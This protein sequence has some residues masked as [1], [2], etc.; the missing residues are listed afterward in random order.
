MPTY[1]IVL[2][3]LAAYLIG[4][5]C[6]AVIVSKLCHLPDPRTHGSNNP[7]A[8]N[9]LRLAGK[10]MALGVLLADALK[11]TLPVVIAKACHVDEVALGWIAL[12]AILG[13]IYPLFFAFQ[14]GKGVATALGALIGLHP[15]LAVLVI[16]TWVCVAAFTRYSSLASLIALGLMPLY[17]LYSLPPASE[18]PL[19]LIT[20]LIWYQH[21]ANW[22]RLR[23]G[24][25]SKINFSK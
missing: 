22:A 7:G 10:W 20:L 8:T 9:V 19:C 5:L 21:R 25:E 1:V 4:S 15:L 14:G 6:S 16:S 2:F 13:H 11:G 12:A 24:T 18:I 3:I 17:A 23:T